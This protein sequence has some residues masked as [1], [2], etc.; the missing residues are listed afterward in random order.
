MLAKLVASLLVRR[1]IVSQW[2]LC[3]LLSPIIHILYPERAG[4]IAV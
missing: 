3:S 4:D 2:D 1:S